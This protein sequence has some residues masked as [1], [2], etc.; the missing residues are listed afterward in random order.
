LQLRIFCRSFK[1]GSLKIHRSDMTPNHTD[2]FVNTLGSCMSKTIGRKLWSTV[3]ATAL[4]L[5]ACG[6]T[7]DAPEAAFTLQLLH[8]SDADGS[9]STALNSVANLSGMIQKFRAQYPQQT[10]TVSSGDNYIPGPRFNAANDSSLNAALGVAEVGRADIAFLNAM[11]VQASAIGN[12][13][14]DLGTRQFADMIRSSG[15]WSGAR[16]PYLAYNVDFAADS[17]VASL[18]LANGGKA[19]EQSGKLTGWTVVDVGGQKIGVIGASSPVF[20]NITSP[21]KLQFMPALTSSEVDVTGLASVIQKG[22]DEMTAAGINKV[23]LLAHMQTLAIEKALAQ[24]LKNVDIIVAGGSNTLLSDANDVL[25]TGD[26]SAGD[27]P[28]ETKDAA[29]QPTVVVN[30]DADYKYLGRFMAPFDDKGVLMPQRFDS[31]LSGAW[32]TSETDDSA[33]GVTVSGLVTQVRDAIKAVLKTKDGNVFGKTGEFLEGRRAA[34]RNE[35]TN[36]GNL[37]ADANLW[38]AQR[39][40]PTVQISLKNGG[41]IRSEIGEVL[42]L[43]GATSAAVLT[44]PKA[45]AEAKRQAG[46]VSQLAVETALKFNNKLWAFNVTATQLKSLLEHGVA[47]LGSQGR[48]PQVGGMSFS[49]DPSRTAQALDANFVVTT[50]GERIRSLKVGSDV[51]VQNGV[52]V[53]NAQRTF[54]MVTLDFLAKGTTDAAG[55]GDSYPFPATADFVNLVDLK[56]TMTEATAGGAAS[57]STATLGSEQDAFMKYMKSQFGTTAFGV[58]D[59]PSA[60]DTRIQNLSQRSDTVLN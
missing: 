29:G 53:G 16:F 21:G 14:L 5:S 12:H 52:L 8:I 4:V 2:S 23:V 22:V 39:L 40:D 32:V 41:G 58:K 36:F 35:E 26:K 50:A 42:A 38:Y 48:F 51:V 59:T 30:V 3:L 10:L 1:K 28:Y 54:R 44:A 31:K 17:D 27:Y 55:G 60:Q 6:G 18:K 34:V 57:T 15:A 13:E 46:E 49:Y 37:T 56:T 11:G 24:R 25:R 47:V 19:S 7:S 45:N 33:G 43:P 20:A 9:D